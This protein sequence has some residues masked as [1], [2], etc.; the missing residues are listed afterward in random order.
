MS[1]Q[2]SK[3]NCSKDIIAFLD[4]E[5]NPENLIQDTLKQHGQE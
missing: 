5:F 2:K 3:K 4:P 1:D